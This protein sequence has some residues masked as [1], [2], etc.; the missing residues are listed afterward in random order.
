MCFCNVCA[1]DWTVPVP[2]ARRFA[3]IEDLIRRTGVRRDELA[4]LAEIGALNSLGHDRRGALWQIERAVRPGGAL[5]EG[6]DDSAEDQAP[7]SGLR[8]PGGV[9]AAGQEPGDGGRDRAG[10][11]GA[12][13]P[14][15]ENEPAQSDV[16]PRA[17]DR[18]L[19]GHQPHDRPASDVDAPP[20]SRR[21]R[22]AA[23]D[24]PA[25][26]PQRAARADGRHGHHAAAA[27]HGER[28]RL[29]HARR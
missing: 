1:H 28:V 25:A 11:P 29:P 2:A 23:S 7:G 18:R 10:R 4:V 12:R 17:D 5:F 15:P 6:V 3:T 24:R 8:A 21:A 14:E 16:P 22:R 13:S 20:R 9:T 27:W 26:R 19:R